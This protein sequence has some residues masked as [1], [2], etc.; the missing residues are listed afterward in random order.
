MSWGRPLWSP[1]A[2][3]GISWPATH[4]LL[5]G[6]TTSGMEQIVAQVSR[7]RKHPWESSPTGAVDV[8]PDTPLTQVYSDYLHT[9]I[10]EARDFCLLDEWGWITAAQTLP[11][12]GWAT[13]LR[14]AIPLSN[15]SINNTLRGLVLRVSREIVSGDY[16]LLGDDRV[17]PWREGRLSAF[18]P[19]SAARHVERYDF[20]SGERAENGS[21]SIY[22]PVTFARGRLYTTPDPMDFPP[23]GEPVSIRLVAASSMP[24]DPDYAWDDSDAADLWDLVASSPEIASASRSDLVGSSD[25]NDNSTQRTSGYLHLPLPDVPGSG[26]VWLAY[27]LPSDTSALPDYAT[28]VFRGIDS[29]PRLFWS[30]PA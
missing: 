7:W 19:A 25:N 23:W 21:M 4:P 15:P 12:L 29:Q 28:Q 22:I 24:S 20:A 18:A 17:R 9:A 3:D 14:R 1:V 13:E 16:A 5:R 8:P 6:G 2:G 30:E 26:R 11:T 27:L 10:D